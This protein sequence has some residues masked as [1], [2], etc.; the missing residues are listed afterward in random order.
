[1]KFRKQKGISKLVPLLLSFA[2]AVI[3]L[4]VG[5]QILGGIQNTQIRSDLLTNV[6]GGN[7]YTVGGNITGKGLSGLSTIGDFLPTIA[8]V[9]AAV[10]VIGLVLAIGLSRKQ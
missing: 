10:V 1:M 9:I 5:A 3:V 6:T 4:G 8:T 2:V 7:N